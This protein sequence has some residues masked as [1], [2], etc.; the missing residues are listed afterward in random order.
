MIRIFLSTMLVSILFLSC[1][2][3]SNSEEKFL[4][5]DF[6][7]NVGSEAFEYGQNYT[8]NDVTVNFEIAQFYIG[9]INLD[10]DNGTLAFPDQ[11]LLAKPNSETFVSDEVSISSISK[12]DFFVGVD[13]IFN[14][15]T[16]TDFTERSAD[17]PL[18][19][20][21]PSMH[22][23]WNSGYKFLR[24]DGEVDTDADGITDTSISYHLGTDAL[25]KNVSIE[26]EKTIDIGNNSLIFSFDLMSFFEGVDL[27]TELDTHTGNNLPLA[28][29]LQE[30][31][32]QSITIK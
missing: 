20:Q 15:Q 28:Q 10:T 19:V 7:F 26:T 23:S 21:D 4:Q 22:W 18:G 9:G 29:R 30:N 24:I 13:P 16:E 12:I 32:G 2:E 25:L 6:E 1:E 27:V 3:D 11:Y 17:D 5:F 14:A 31:M 8:I